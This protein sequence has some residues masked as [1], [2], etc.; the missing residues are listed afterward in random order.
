MTE[1][2]SGGQRRS[3]GTSKE[4]LFCCKQSP[5]QAARANSRSHARV[6]RQRNA[7]KIPAQEEENER[8][9]VS[10]G[11][12]GVVAYPPRRLPSRG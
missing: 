3:D 10:T 8:E 2:K 9:S 1:F 5:P 6:T 12:V 7:A 11:R 4:E